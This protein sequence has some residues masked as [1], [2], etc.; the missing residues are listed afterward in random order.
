MSC[1]S[2]NITS[3]KEKREKRETISQI[4]SIEYGS[5]SGRNPDRRLQPQTSA[6]ICCWLHH[7]SEGLRKMQY[8]H[9]YAAES[10]RCSFLLQLEWVRRMDVSFLHHRTAAGKERCMLLHAAPPQAKPPTAVTWN[11]G[12]RFHPDEAFGSGFFPAFIG[13]NKQNG[14]K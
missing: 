13:L 14:T 6:L 1:F 9:I 12:K 7:G 4:G 8:L 5:A 10:C 2:K 3:I 11:A